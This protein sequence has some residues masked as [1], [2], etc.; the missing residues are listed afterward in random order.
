MFFYLIHS[1]P[2]SKE[3]T[4]EKRNLRTIVFGGLVYVG[5]HACLSSKYMESYYESF[6]TLKQYFYYMLVIDLLIFAL[7]YKIQTDKLIL[8]NIDVGFGSKQQPQ[9]IHN[10]PQVFDIPD[11]I[12]GMY[13]PVQP[14]Q[15]MQTPK[16]K[17][18]TT[19]NTQDTEVVSPKK[20]KKEKKAVETSDEEEQESV[21]EPKKKTSEVESP[22]KAKKK[23]KKIEKQTQDEEEQEVE[24]VIKKNL[25]SSAK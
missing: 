10:P 21:P 2:H 12:P 5:L 11:Y 8:T 3:L 9:V 17:V 19:K 25:K 1:I 20:A 13:A 14:I 23:P 18:V 6:V 22:K 16:P 15:P 7:M 4:E 24:E